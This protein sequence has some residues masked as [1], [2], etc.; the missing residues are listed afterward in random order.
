MSPAARLFATIVFTCLPAGV[1]AATGT[2]EIASDERRR[3][4]SW[5]QSRATARAAL[6]IQ[7]TT[8]FRIDGAVTALR[9]SRRHRG[10]DT[11]VDLGAGWQ[12]R[13]GPVRY[14]AGVVAHLFAGGAGRLDYAEVQ[15][16]LGSTIGPADF[17]L[18]ASYAPRQNAIGGE[19]LY[20]AADARVAVVGTPFSIVGGLGRS[21]GAVRDPI[22]AARLRPENRYM[23]WRLGVEHVSGPVT[24]SLLYL[25]T[26]LSTPQSPTTRGSGDTLIL[27][28]TLTL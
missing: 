28:L 12:D 18:S 10:A 15:A 23:D 2:I 9:R 3:G 26:D 24:A 7:P 13:S 19:V 16:G 11:V 14:D 4:I 22:R 17:G 25:G 8:T 5:S 1:D 27:R 20:L 21:S 6:S